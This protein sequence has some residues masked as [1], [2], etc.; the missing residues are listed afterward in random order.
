MSTVETSKIFVGDTGT[1]IVVTIKDQDNAVIDVSAALTLEI[2][3]RRPDG[4]KI[5][6]TATFTTDGTDGQI[7]FS[8]LSTDFTIKG[9]YQ[10]QPRVVTATADQHATKAEAEVFE[11]L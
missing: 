10:F 2:K 1:N 8:S 3:M 11:H 6:K 5:T 9:I 7:Q 4:T